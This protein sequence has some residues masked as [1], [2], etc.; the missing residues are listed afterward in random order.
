MTFGECQNAS[1]TPIISGS[2]KRLNFDTR[3]FQTISMMN[4]NIDIENS[5]E[6]T[7]E[8]ENGQH[9]VITVTVARGCISAQRNHVQMSSKL[10]ISIV[11]APPFCMVPSSIPVDHHFRFSFKQEVSRGQPGSAYFTGVVIATTKQRT[12]ITCGG[13]K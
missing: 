6:V 4:V 2:E 7:L 13:E 5:T 1:S 10:M 12:I 9:D 11:M 3:V 8:P